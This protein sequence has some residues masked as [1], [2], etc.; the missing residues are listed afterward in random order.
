MPVQER[1]ERQAPNGSEQ[2]HMHVEESQSMAR[3]DSYLAAPFEE[4]HSIQIRAAASQQ[5]HG[6]ARRNPFFN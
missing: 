5:V 2:A 4:M 1:I 3:N 6:S